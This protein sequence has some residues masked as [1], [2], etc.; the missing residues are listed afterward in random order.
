M[1]TSHLSETI[2]DLVCVGPLDAGREV[3]RL[4]VQVSAG[5]AEDVVSE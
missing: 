3:L 1:E 5:V 2:D 4:G